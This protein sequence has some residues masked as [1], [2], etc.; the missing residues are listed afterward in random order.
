MV[1]KQ[2]EGKDRWYYTGPYFGFLLSCRNSGD[3]VEILT[4]NLKGGAKLKKSL[5]IVVTIL[6]VSLSA[7]LGILD[8]QRTIRIEQ[9]SQKKQTSQVKP[10]DKEGV[11]KTPTNGQGTPSQQ[12]NQSEEGTVQGDDTLI[13]QPISFTGG[14]FQKIYGQVVWSPDGNHFS[15]VTDLGGGKLGIYLAKASGGQDVLLKELNYDSVYASPYVY[16]CWTGDSTQLYYLYSTSIGAEYQPYLKLG[17]LNIATGEEKPYKM[18]DMYVSPGSVTWAP[19]AGKLSF[20]AGGGIQRVDLADGH[21]TRLVRID[22]RDGLLQIAGSPTGTKLAYTRIFGYQSAAQERV[23]VLDLLTGKEIQVSPK[24]KYS[25]K[26]MWFDKGDKLGFLTANSKAQGG[27]S[28]VQGEAGPLSYSDGI[29][30]VT[31]QGKSVIDLKYKSENILGFSPLAKQDALEVYTGSMVQ[32]AGMG[33]IAFVL[34]THRIVQLPDGT[35]TWEKKFPKGQVGENN[36]VQWVDE[37][38][39]INWVVTPGSNTKTIVLRDIG[40]RELARVDGVV[41]QTYTLNKGVA[42]VRQSGSSQD[43]WFLSKTGKLNQL[44]KDS[45]T[46]TITGVKDNQIIYLES[47]TDGKAPTLHMLNL[48]FKGAE[49]LAEE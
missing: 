6:A 8:N 40:D 37:Q 31:A 25:W 39:W 19:Q 32:M 41:E 21:T 28:I 44:T 45:T 23:F 15:Y 33:G 1:H 49:A 38:T 11:T 2:F 12:E 43:I 13:V 34:D 42:F 48:Q 30:V 16:L 36:S 47:T 35:I 22:G 27:F 20:W 29:S 10:Q 18:R 14:N 46:K 5:W 17:K 26:P 3:S 4:D 24:D 7:T 9:D